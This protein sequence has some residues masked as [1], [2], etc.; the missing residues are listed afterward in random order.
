M[1]SAIHGALM[2]NVV[3][4]RDRFVNH[5]RKLFGAARH[6]SQLS[7]FVF[8]LHFDYHPRSLAPIRFL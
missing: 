1:F 8:E 2:I 5:E 3:G 7:R 6:P 4:N